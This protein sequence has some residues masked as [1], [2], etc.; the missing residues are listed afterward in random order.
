MYVNWCERSYLLYENEQQHQIVCTYNAIIT[1]DKQCENQPK[2][3]KKAIQNRYA[4]IK[5]KEE[6]KRQQQQQQQERIE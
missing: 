5:K 3:R 6:K 2:E 4:N 1:N